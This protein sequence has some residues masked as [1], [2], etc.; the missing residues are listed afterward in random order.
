MEEVSQDMSSRR[1]DSSNPYVRND[2]NNAYGLP[3]MTAS[4][5]GSFLDRFRNLENDIADQTIKNSQ[6]MNGSYMN[7][8]S[9]TMTY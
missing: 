3:N 6:I 9:I 5:D 1:A 7:N 8:T 4:Q 2:S